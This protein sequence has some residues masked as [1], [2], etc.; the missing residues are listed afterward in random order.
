MAKK[1]KEEQEQMD[2]IDV[3]TKNAKKILAYAKDYKSCQKDRIDYLAKEKELKQKVI[4]EIR[5]AKLSPMD[6]G[7]IKFTVDN[8]KISMKPRDELIQIKEIGIDGEDT[9][10]KDAERKDEDI[11]E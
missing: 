11:R 9:E 10:E 4:E 3:K 8:F 7:T 6:D 2:L 5:K 1:N